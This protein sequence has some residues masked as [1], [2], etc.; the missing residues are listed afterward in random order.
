MGDCIEDENLH[1]YS[2]VVVIKGICVKG[3]DRP[4]ELRGE[5]RLIRSEMTNWSLGKFFL[6]HF[7]GLHTRSAKNH[8]MP[9]NNF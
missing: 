7:K 6:S 1:T 9:L 5:S 2:T 8:W 4:F 3:I